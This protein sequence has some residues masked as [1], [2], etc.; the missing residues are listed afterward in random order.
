MSDL[1]EPRPPAAV[2]P[3]YDPVQPESSRK[4]ARQTLSRF[5]APLIGLGALLLK[6]GSLFKFA[7]IFIA[8]GGYALIFGWPFAVGFV[9]LIL[10]H[11][12]GHF[13]EAQ[14]EGLHPKVPVFIPFIGA[15]VKM[16]AGNPWQ[17]ARIAIAG[18]I[19]GG[20]GAMVDPRR[21]RRLPRRTVPVARRRPQQGTRDLRALRIDGG[22]AHPR[23]ARLLHRP[24]PPLS[25]AALQAGRNDG[26]GDPKAARRSTRMCEE[27]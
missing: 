8:V 15:Y 24:A 19:V 12:L 17:A 2:P 21:R 9:A 26:A 22:G 5:T 14:R 3:R 4:S 23:N 1:F 7:T 25:A 27:T 18:P 13:I 6:L 16:T 20:C 10:V 11:E